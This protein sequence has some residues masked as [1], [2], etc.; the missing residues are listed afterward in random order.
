EPS[1]LILY[2]RYENSLYAITNDLADRGVTALV[3]SVIGDVTD[4]ARTSAVFAQHRPHLV[5]HAAAHKHV[6]LMEANPCEAIKNNVV[7]T[8][9][10]A[11]MSRDYG[12]ERFV[13]V[14][15][16][17]AVNPTSV[18]GASKRVAELIVQS[19]GRD[20]GNTL[21]VTVRFGNVLGSNGS[22]IPRMLDQIRAGGPVTVTDPEIRR[23]FML[24]PEA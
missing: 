1:E 15:T 4:V 8:R 9:I 16:D 3:H 19:I 18:M 23:Y 22:V 20:A 2:E 24:I 17:K 11:E 5:F 12:V 21:F 13:M 14:S 7:G 10:V 6:P